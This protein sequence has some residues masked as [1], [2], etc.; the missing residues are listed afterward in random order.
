MINRPMQHRSRRYRVVII[1]L[2][3][4]LAIIGFAFALINSALTRYVESPR[5]RVLMEQE[6]AR[7]LHFPSGQ[8]TPIRRTGL[9]SAQSEQFKGRDGRKAVTSLDAQGITA[10]FNP[11]GILLRRWQIDDLHIGRGNAGIQVYEPKP[12]PLPV[13]PWYFVFLPDHVYLKHV[14]SDAV[15]VT[16]PTRGEQSGI[17][18]THLVITPHGR[19]FEY[20]AASGVLRNPSVPEM[21]VRQVHLLITKQLFTLYTLDLSSGGGT[22]HGQGSTAIT[23]EKRANFNFSWNDLPVPE[24]LPKTWSGNFAGAADGDLHW[25]GNNYTLAAA[26]VIG[27]V[28]VNGGHVGG[29]KFLDTIAAVTKHD[30]LARLELDVCRSKFRWHEG[31]CELNDIEIEQTGKFRIE[32]TVSFSER[33]LTGMIRIGM[34]HQYLDWLP[35]PEEVFSQ[36]T[37][38]Y[39]W[40][41]VHLSGTL[42]SP[43][44][45]LSPRV[46]QALTESPGALLGAGLRA[47]G[48]WLREEQG[49]R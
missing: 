16:W 44:Q 42:D 45:D 18:G 37:G 7:G 30:D 35:H 43:K 33:A 39:L 22:I 49:H 21:A 19:D 24:W 2:G 5:F 13:R 38:G 20:H 48:V 32:G 9:L 8:F 47:L 27:A 36:E 6:T 23:G 14:W 41:T 40:T 3:S 15:D 4:I 11:L 31:D 29:L 17:F 25:T 12:A 10:R 28:K 26:T 1:V 46:I 34:T